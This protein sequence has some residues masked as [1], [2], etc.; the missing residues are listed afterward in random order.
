MTMNRGLIASPMW[1]AEIQLCAS[2]VRTVC[3]RLGVSETSLPVSD[4]RAEQWFPGEAFRSLAALCRLTLLETAP[5]T[6]NLEQR[7]LLRVVSKKITRRLS[8]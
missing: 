5:A 1:L 2:L 4:E 8:L 3:R 6:L 7:L